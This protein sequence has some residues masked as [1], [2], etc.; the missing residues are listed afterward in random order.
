M[1]DLTYPKSDSN[2]A[3]GSRSVRLRLA[4]PD[5]VPALEALITRSAR[6]LS[7]PYYTARQTE[8]A[9]RH[10]FGVDTR[11]VADRTYFV[12]EENGRL[13]ACGGWSRR[14]TLYGSDRAKSGPD[15][16][17]DPE[18]EPARLRAFFVDPGAARRGLGR[19]LVDE[20]LRAARAAGFRAI[21]LVAT[22]PGEP[23]YLACGFAAVERFDLELP[24]GV[25][26]PVARMRL[27][28]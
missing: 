19:R 3:G 23:L 10:V 24:D 27:E 8:A 28:I 18:T 20:C 9:V 7:V 12:L 22:L 26:L 16:I 6:G 5:D 15:P 21:E 25:R 13:L 17:L 2:A 1:S 11:L 14:R 4:R